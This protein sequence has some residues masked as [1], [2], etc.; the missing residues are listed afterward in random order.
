MTIDQ[1]DTDRSLDRQIADL[2]MVRKRQRIMSTWNYLLSKHSKQS[3]MRIIRS[4]FSGRCRKFL[5]LPVDQRNPNEN[6]VRKAC[7]S[8]SFF[9]CI[10][11]FWKDSSVA[12]WFWWFSFP[13]TKFTATCCCPKPYWRRCEY[14]LQPNSDAL[15]S[16]IRRI[17]LSL[18][19][20]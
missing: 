20:Y 6:A 14:I 9:T 1:F 17:R 12:V 4:I 15:F 3:I 2:I 5:S 7:L 8:A 11:T 10:R 18:K 13:T 16:F 19:A